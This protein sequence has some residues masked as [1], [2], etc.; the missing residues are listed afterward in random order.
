MLI[1]SSSNLEQAFSKDPIGK[2]KGQLPGVLLLAIGII[3][4]QLPSFRLRD[5]RASQTVDLQWLSPAQGSYAG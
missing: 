2:T 1:I 4:Y 3:R 5:L